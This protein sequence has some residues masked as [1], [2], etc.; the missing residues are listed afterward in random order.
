MCLSCNVFEVME[1]LKIRITVHHLASFRLRLSDAPPKHPSAHARLL[2]Q[3][4]QTNLLADFEV[5]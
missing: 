3:T 5:Q 1:S 2:D 4:I